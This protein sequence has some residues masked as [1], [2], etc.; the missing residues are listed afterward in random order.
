MNKQKHA[1]IERGQSYF[2]KVCQKNHHQANPRHQGKGE[3]IIVIED[4]GKTT[5]EEEKDDKRQGLS[6]KT[7]WDLY[8]NKAYEFQEGIVNFNHGL[9]LAKEH[10]LMCQVPAPWKV[11]RGFQEHLAHSW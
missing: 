6:G 2:G 1:F 10:P 11:L 4:S 3:H 7:I 8:S 5:E 9:L